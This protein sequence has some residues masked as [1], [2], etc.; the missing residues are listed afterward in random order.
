MLTRLQPNQVDSSYMIEEQSS[1][2]IVLVKNE[3]KMFYV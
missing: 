1:L 3:S 2:C